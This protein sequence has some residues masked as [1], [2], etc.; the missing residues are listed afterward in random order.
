MAINYTEH[1]FGA[2]ETIKAIIRKYNHMNMSGDLLDKLMVQYNELN[3]NQ[4]PR[5]GQKVKIPLF[6]GFVGMKDYKSE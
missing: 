6:V 5:P 1:V 2:N 3:N 4:I